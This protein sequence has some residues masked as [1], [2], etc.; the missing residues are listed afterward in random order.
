M[1][2]M[3]YLLGPTSYILHPTSYIL[4]PCPMSYILCPISYVLYPMSFV[5]HPT[6]CLYILYPK[7]YF[8]W[9]N[10]L[11]FCCQFSIVC[12]KVFPPS[13]IY[14]KYSMIMYWLAMGLNIIVECKI[15]V[16]LGIKVERG[17]F[18]HS[19]CVARLKNKNHS[20]WHFVFVFKIAYQKSASYPA[21]KCLKVLS[22]VGLRRI[23]GGPTNNFSH[24]QHELRLS[25]GCDNNIKL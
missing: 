13:Q 9:I 2:P 19:K 17:A 22:V 24:S 5:L 18:N 20:S 21:W 11:A 4:H 12:Y 16:A 15:C 6:S 14:L 23:C 3:S 7:S 25:W 10:V 8:E 1:V